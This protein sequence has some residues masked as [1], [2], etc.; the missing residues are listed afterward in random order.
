MPSDKYINCSIQTHFYFHAKVLFYFLPAAC[1]LFGRKKI[2]IER[3]LEISKITTFNEK[4]V[5]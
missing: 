3:F 5:S 2:N 1:K 4:L